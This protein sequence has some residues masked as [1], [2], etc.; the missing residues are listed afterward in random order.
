MKHFLA[1]TRRASL[2]PFGI[3]PVSAPIDWI[4]GTPAPQHRQA[5]TTNGSQ[6]LF[7]LSVIPG[8]KIDSQTVQVFK[9]GLL[10][11][12]GYSLSYQPAIRTAFI[13]FDSAPLLTDTV[14]LY[15]F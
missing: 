6:T 14:I 2:V 8:G 13:N 9:N 5:L 15:I 4:E 7:A 12:T 11:T 10:Q 3:L 1:M